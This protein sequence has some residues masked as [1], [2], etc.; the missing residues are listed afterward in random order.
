MGMHSLFDNFFIQFFYNFEAV[1]RPTNRDAE[2]LLLAGGKLVAH[3]ALLAELVETFVDVAV[4]LPELMAVDQAGEA[5]VGGGLYPEVPE[6]GQHVA[7]GGPHAVQP[8]KSQET[9]CQAAGMLDCGQEMPVM[10]SKGSETNTMS[11]MTFSR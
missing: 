9:P 3:L 7:D 6:L 1:G 10:K 11:S 4:G 5:E 2:L 8:D